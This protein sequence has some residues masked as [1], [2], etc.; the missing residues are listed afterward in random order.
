MDGS[1]D[2]INNELQ[3]LADEL[4][5]ILNEMD[6]VKRSELAKDLKERMRDLEEFASETV[7]SPELSAALRRA[8]R[9][10]EQMEEGKSPQEIKESLKALAESMDLTKMELQ[11]IAQ[12]AKDM[13]KLEE[14]LE[15]L[16]RMVPDDLTA[17][18]LTAINRIHAGRSLSSVLSYLAKR[19]KANTHTFAN[20]LLSVSSDN[21]IVNNAPI[22]YPK[23]HR[24]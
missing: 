19:F 8:M 6:P 17:F 9:Q 12:S 23:R 21:Q 18:Y 24:R 10:L 22:S 3:Q 11:Q 5:D 13:K 2:E 15:A 1:S 4:A 14:A 7:G 20:M 16:D